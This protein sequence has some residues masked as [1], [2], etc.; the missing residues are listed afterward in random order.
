LVSLLSSIK[1]NTFCTQPGKYKNA[2]QLPQ[3]VI[4]VLFF[5]ILLLAPPLLAK[6][7]LDKDGD[8]LKNF[9]EELLGTKK[10]NPDSDKDGLTDGEEVFIYFTDPLKKDTD[11]D[12]RWDGSEVLGGSDPLDPSSK[13]ASDKDM[14]G[15]LDKEEK[16][17][18]TKKS[19]P[20]SDK[21]GLIDGDEVNLYGTDPLSADTDNDG[22]NDKTEILLGT[23]PNDVASVPSEPDQDGD[24]LSDA[25]EVNLGTNQL[26]KD[27]DKDKLDDGYEVLVL[28]TDPTKKDTD[29]DKIN[30][31]FD[32]FPLDPNEWADT[33]GNGIGDNTSPP[34]AQI[35]TDADGMLDIFD[36]DDDND[37]VVDLVDSAPLDSGNTNEKILP[38]NSIYSGNLSEHSTNKN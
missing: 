13:S 30:D 15:L 11:G 31:K 20:D 7:N 22:I 9:E 18:G 26:K 14:D 35:D 24:G 33:D 32:F 3:L 21:D 38:L 28:G 8:G 25:E 19:S 1:V 6:N 34:P 29:G 36:W 37:G 10:N 2:L 5:S 16:K 4:L 23:D 27:S 17:L 12:K